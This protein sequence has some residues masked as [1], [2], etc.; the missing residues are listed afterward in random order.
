MGAIQNGR[1]IGSG[2]LNFWAHR[3]HGSI[4]VKM[5]VAKMGAYEMGVAKMG[6]Y[7]MG[8]AQMG[9]YEMGAAQMGS[10]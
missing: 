3:G 5:G 4:W 8:V 6:A 7:E 9:A 10:E 1:R 2:A